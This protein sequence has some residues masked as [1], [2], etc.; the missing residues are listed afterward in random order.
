[1]EV[2]KVRSASEI[3]DGF[4]GIA[5]YPNGDRGWYKEGNIHRLDGPAIE[6]SN[7]TKFWRIEG[8]SHRTDGPAVE[9]PDGTKEWWIEGKNYSENKF[10]SLTELSIFLGKEKNKYDL[11]WLRFLTEEGIKEFAI[12]P[13]MEFVKHERIS[14]Y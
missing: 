10:K 11:E 7:G 4:T 9:Y 3:P 13:G 2:I 14:D 5:E 1:M 6:Y 12:V 8:I